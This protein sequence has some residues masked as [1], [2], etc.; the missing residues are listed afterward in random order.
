MKSS[1]GSWSAYGPAY[2]KTASTIFPTHR[3]PVSRFS[4]LISNHT[5]IIPRP[6]QP[7]TAS[8]I[9][10][11]YR[12]LKNISKSILA[13]Q[14]KQTRG[15]L[16]TV[17]GRLNT[18]AYRPFST[19]TRPRPSLYV[20]LCRKPTVKPARMKQNDHQTSSAD[21]NYLEVWF[22]KTNSFLR[23]KCDA[24]KVIL[25][26]VITTWMNLSDYVTSVSQ[27][28]VASVPQAWPK[29]ALQA[30]MG[31]TALVVIVFW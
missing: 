20:S 8:S 17:K 25:V 19:L 7:V 24:L 6:K 15:N 9:H 4:Y 1:D 22:L 11:W 2:S 31:N 12:N 29:T 27:A 28:R 23:T 14:S 13:L 3:V 30:A 16:R 18:D 26:T 10:T 21:V 5:P